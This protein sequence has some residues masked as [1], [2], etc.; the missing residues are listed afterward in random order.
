MKK[1]TRALVFGAVVAALYAVLTLAFSWISYGPV[2]FRIAEAL[3]AFPLFMPCSIPGLTVGCVVANLIG[4]YGLYDIIIGSLATCIGAL[5]TRFLRK[6]P[7]LAMLAPV[8]SNAVLVGS[9]L[10]FVV[11]DS[12]TLLLNMVTVGAG[13][14][15]ICLCLGLP[16]YHLLHKYLSFFE[17]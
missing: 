14:L 15:V 3:T 17:V 13:E 9:M 8:V 4:G 2:Q 7:W 10:Y 11:P 16:L 12:P 5:G 6:K 1:N